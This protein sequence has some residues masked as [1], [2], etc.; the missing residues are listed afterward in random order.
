MDDRALEVGRKYLIKHTSH[1]AP[2]VITAL[3][4]R[5]NVGTLEHELAATLQ[6]ND[7]GSVRLNLLRPMAVDAYAENRATG[8]FILIDPQT[9]GTVAAGM[10]TGIVPAEEPDDAADAWGRVT[11]GEREA[12]WG[13]RGGVLELRGPAG[14]IDTIER[15]LFT[16]GAVTVRVNAESDAFLL[17][18]PLLETVTEA[19][20]QS[21][22]LTLVA[23]EID[24]Y[25]LTARVE[26]ESITVDAAEP[27]HALSAVHQLLRKA[28]IFVSA[29]GANL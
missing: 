4:H 13:H 14:L 16:I 9:N 28:S 15:S 25:E 5:T 11:E 29:E 7:I 27:M 24:T 18:P 26:E 6:M 23:R 21:G 12:R 10:V 8:A 1:T 19:Q 17:H 3:E 2:A 22:I 20:T